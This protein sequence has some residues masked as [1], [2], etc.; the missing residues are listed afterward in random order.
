[1]GGQEYLFV[2]GCARSGTSV[3]A[4]LL[5]SHH[6]IAMGRER[7]SGRYWRG[8]LPQRLFEKERFCRQLQEHDSHHESLS[9]YYEEVYHRFD[10]CIYRGDKGPA[11]ADN[12]NPLL[13]SYTRPKVIFMLRNCFDVAN[14]FNRRAEQ[15]SKQP[16]RHKW[17]VDRRCESAIVEWNRS[18]R[19]SLEVLDKVDFL[20]I[21]YERL[22]ADNAI[23]RR[24]FDFL[25]LPITDEVTAAWQRFMARKRVLE[26]SRQLTLSSQEMLHIMRSAD[27]DAYRR[28]LH[29]AE[30]DHL[31][32]PGGGRL[33]LTFPR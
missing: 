23:L 5:R 29:I 33:E 15:T 21:V 9:H 1:M 12:Y 2:T 26:N 31:R 4:E 8:E 6:K 3:M 24:V 25:S 7:F 32:H 19:N 14:S 16:E 20:F 10:Q 11:I 22:F 27:I 30:H 17:P 13:E 18:I 28:V